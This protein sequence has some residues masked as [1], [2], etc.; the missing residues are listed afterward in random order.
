MTI[1]EQKKLIE[2]L[3]DCEA[4]MSRSDAETFAMFRKRHKDDE[5]LD[6]I[7]RKRLLELHEKYVRKKQSTG[8]PLD[9]LFGK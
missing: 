9:K 7:S 1:I 3:Q 6:L 4:R 8:N 2:E 5:D